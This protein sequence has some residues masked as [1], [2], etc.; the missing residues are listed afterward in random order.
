MHMVRCVVRMCA[1]RLMHALVSVVVDQNP[2]SPGTKAIPGGPEQFH[3]L[4]GPMT[5]QTLRGLKGHGSQHWRG[6]RM[7]LNRVEVNGR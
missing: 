1:A 4:K 3:P 5:T 6:D 7:G 2:Y